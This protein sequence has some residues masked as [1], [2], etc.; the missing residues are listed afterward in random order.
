MAFNH[1]HSRRCAINTKSSLANCTCG[2][3][4]RSLRRRLDDMRVE[5]FQLRSELHKKSFRL[6]CLKKTLQVLET[7]LEELDGIL[8]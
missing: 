7:E 2:F 5:N 8:R 1:C 3:T 6:M 4:G